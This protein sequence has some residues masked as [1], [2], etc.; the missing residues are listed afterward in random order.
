[1]EFIKDDKGIRIKDIN[2]DKVVIIIEFNIPF[3]I[4]EDIII[5]MFN[6]EGVMFR[7]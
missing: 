5:I 3:D 4:K 2:N 1:L 6:K 7:E